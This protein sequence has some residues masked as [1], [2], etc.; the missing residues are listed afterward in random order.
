MVNEQ[1]TQLKAFK[2]AMKF[3][4]F[5]DYEAAHHFY[6]R[7]EQK[8][9]SLASTSEH[10][11]RLETLMADAAIT[12]AKQN[13]DDLEK[14]NQ[15]LDAAVKHSIYAKINRSSEI[16]TIEQDAI[17]GNLDLVA[18]SILSSEGIDY[19]RA[20]SLLDY[21]EKFGID[22]ADMQINLYEIHKELEPQVELLKHLGVIT[23]HHYKHL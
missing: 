16:E 18:S 2:Q 23:E 7:I 15:Y 12:S 20:K 5:G 9:Q 22:Q 3:S 10:F 1:V 19:H 8:S 6:E 17:Q 21:S 14:V 13:M 11:S 4:A